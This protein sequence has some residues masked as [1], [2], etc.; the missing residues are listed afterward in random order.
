MV[1]LSRGLKRGLL[2][3]AIILFAA[4]CASIGVSVFFLSSPIMRRNVVIRP[5]EIYCK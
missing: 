5:Y 1:V 2:I 3:T 4:G